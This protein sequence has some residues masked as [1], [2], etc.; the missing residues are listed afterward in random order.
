[1]AAYLD[2]WIDPHAMEIKPRTL[3]DYRACVR[4]YATPISGICRSKP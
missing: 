1:V 2:E 4:L 3:A